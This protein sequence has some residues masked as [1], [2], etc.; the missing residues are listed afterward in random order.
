MSLLL[1]NES[2]AKVTYLPEFNLTALY[3]MILAEVFKNH[4]LAE[5]IYFTSHIE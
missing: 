4:I 5:Q 2:L 1:K 3:F